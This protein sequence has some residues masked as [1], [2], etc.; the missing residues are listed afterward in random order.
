MW[1]SSPRCAMLVS[2]YQRPAEPVNPH[3]GCAAD[4]PVH[5]LGSDL[6][7]H[8]LEEVCRILSGDLKPLLLGESRCVD[9]DRLH[10]SHHFASSPA[11]SPGSEYNSTT[12]NS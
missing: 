5:H 8:H 1:V 12:Y 11:S 4:V 10:A 9:G 6:A 3:H 7:G 2:A